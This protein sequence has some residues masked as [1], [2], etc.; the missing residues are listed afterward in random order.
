MCFHT[1]ETKRK[2]DEGIDN[3]QPKMKRVDTTKRCSDLIVLGLPWKSEE[4]DVREY[5]EKFGEL[6]LV[7]VMHQSFATTSPSGPGSSGDI[8]FSLSK[9]RVYAQDCG[10]TLNYDQSSAKSPAQIAAGKCKFSWPVWAWNQILCYSTA[11]GGQ[12]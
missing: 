5:F 10:D 11:L 2:G 6:V 8:D 4:E 1:P 3:P 7:Q 9:A 12:C